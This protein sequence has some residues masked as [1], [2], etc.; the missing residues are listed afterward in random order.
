MKL[1][2][3]GRYGTRLMFY[4]AQKHG[5]GFIMLREVAEA[6][7]ISLKYL[8]QLIQP[9]KVARLILSER[10]AHGGYALAK[11]P[12]QISL[13]EIIQALEGPLVFVDCAADESLCERTSLCV[14]RDIWHEIGRMV[15]SYLESLTLEDLQKKLLA[16]KKTSKNKRDTDNIVK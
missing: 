2:T 8:A 11:P 15:Q 16:K 7:Q 13:S 10:G 4:L 9:L 6:E 5:Q 1:S 3:K 14:T 12:G